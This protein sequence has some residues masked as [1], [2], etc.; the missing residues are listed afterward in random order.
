MAAICFIV[1]IVVQVF[2]FVIK[3]HFETLLPIWFNN[4]MPSR[5]DHL[6]QKSSGQK[7]EIEKKN[8]IIMIVC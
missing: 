7:I 1:C 6:L 4:F 3:C 8:Q 2:L 5:Q